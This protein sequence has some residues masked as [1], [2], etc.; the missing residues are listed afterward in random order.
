M[1]KN[2]LKKAANKPMFSK[3]ALENISERWIYAL[4][5]LCFTMMFKPVATEIKFRSESVENTSTSE[6]NDFLPA[7]PFPLLP[8][9]QVSETSIGSF[10]RFCLV[11]SK[12]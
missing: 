2:E 9:L 1:K 6:E 3:K 11:C 8:A 7:M 10:I 12:I 5:F 4:L